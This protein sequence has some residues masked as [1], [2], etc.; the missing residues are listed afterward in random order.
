MNLVFSRVLR[1]STPR[2]VGPSVG[3]SV[4][5]SVRR[6]RYLTLNNFTYLC[7]FD[8]YEV[9]LDAYGLSAS[10]AEKKI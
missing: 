5:L 1:D 9:S 8:F 10:F 2:F 7:L 4:G 6:S 3:L